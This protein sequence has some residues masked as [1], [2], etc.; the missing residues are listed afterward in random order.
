MKLLEAVKKGAESKG[1]N[2]EMVDLFNLGFKGCGS[3]L[4]CKKIGA[5]AKCYQKD[6]LS[7][8]LE[9]IHECDG[10]AI[11]TPVYMGNFSSTFYAF[12][13]RLIYSN[14]RYEIGER[15][16]KLSKRIPTGLLI[17]LGADLE[18]Y[19]NVYT[20]TLG[21][22][23]DLLSNVFGPCTTVANVSQALVPDA[24]PYEMG[25]FNMDKIHK[26]VKDHDPIVLKQAFDLG[27]KLA[28][29]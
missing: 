10:F 6:N 24:K 5:P 2:V 11:G 18:T 4:Q 19:K 13:E 27:V 25:M 16:L 1:A 3:C 21:H 14:T 9:K 8:Y 29:K 17:S 20:K 22:N 28:T 12:L 15:H 26:W 23:A 7:P